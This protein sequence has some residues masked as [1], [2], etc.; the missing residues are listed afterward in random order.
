[1]APWATDRHFY[2]KKTTDINWIGMPAYQVDQVHL[3]GLTP[4][5]QY[6]CKVW[7]FIPT[8][9]GE[10]AIGTFTLTSAKEASS[11]NG[12]N[13]INIYPNP[14]VDQVNLDLFTQK[15][16]KV[17]WNI[18]DVTGKIVLSGSES[19]T[20]GYNTLKID[21]AE[22]PKG[23]YLLNAM[24]DDHMQSFRILKQ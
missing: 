18:Y 20:T 4:N 24:L 7:A 2:Y 17:T 6:Q 12:D 1:M 19:I 16:T 10:T 3:T 5:V 15:E 23:V 21:A 11:N 22:L 13:E 9:W 8:Y 14:F